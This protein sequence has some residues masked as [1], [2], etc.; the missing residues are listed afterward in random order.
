VNSWNPQNIYMT[1]LGI[2]VAR[3]CW[4]SQLRFKRMAIVVLRF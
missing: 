2:D 3:F 4:F 1:K